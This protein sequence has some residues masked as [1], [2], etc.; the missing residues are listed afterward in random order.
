[1][2]TRLRIQNWRQ[3]ERVSIDFHPRLTVLTGAN[4]SGKT[5]LLHLL[6]RHWGWDLDYVSGLK[7]DDSGVQKFWAGFW[8][9][10]GHAAPAANGKY[11]S[12]GEITYE[13]GQSGILGISP[14]V[15]EVFKVTMPGR[16]IVPGVY[17]PSHRS[18]YCFQKLTSLPIKLDAREELF[19][20]YLDEVMTRYIGNQSSAS[21]PGLHIKRSLLSLAMFGYGNQ[22]V[23][24]NEEAVQTFEG[25]QSILRTMLPESLGFTGFRIRVPELYLLTTSGEIAFEAVSG[26]VASIIDMVWQ[27]HMYSRIHERFV[28]VIDE[29]EAHLHPALQQRL[30]PDFLKAFP[31]AQFVIATHSPF[32]VTSVADSNV[33][34]LRYNESNQV[35]SELL[36]T[37]NKAGTA[38]EIL[39]EVLGLPSTLPHWAKSRIE[40]I[41]DTFSKTPIT[42]D[43]VAALRTELSEIGMGQFF[44]E[45]LAK[46]AEGQR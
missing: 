21:T 5:T 19:R 27:V 7:T 41:L 37:M 16:Q 18:P 20:V 39:M 4:G 43:S 33:F 2:F 26:G 29:P 1:M 12:I 15:K 3:F 31:K 46:V 30:L 13:N 14:D 38:D 8:G 34:V 22:A 44:P 17:V 10:N 25:F 40:S 9:D 24:R 45:V 42:S 11:I 35:E 28:V 23:E 36:D 32:M 6:N